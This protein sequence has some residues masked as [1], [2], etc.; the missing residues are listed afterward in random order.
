MSTAKVTAKVTAMSTVASAA[1]SAVVAV[2]PGWT[3]LRVASPGDAHKSTPSE[4]LRLTLLD[5]R[6]DALSVCEVGITLRTDCIVT[7]EP[8]AGASVLDLVA[9]ELSGHTELSGPGELSGPANLSAAARDTLPPHI[10]GQHNTGKHNTGQHNTGQHNADR[11]RIGL[12]IVSAGY[13]GI[14]QSLARIEEDIRSV[15]RAT[16]AFDGPKTKPQLV[17]VSD[18]P[19]VSALLGEVDQAVSHVA[20]SLGQLTRLAQIMQHEMARYDEPET[21]RA[22]ELIVEGQSLGRRLEFVV[23]R[24]LF[25]ARSSAQR[26]ST[27]DLNVIKVF[28]VLWAILIPGTTLINWY[29]Q[30]F[31]FMPELSWPHTATVQLIG[32]FVLAALPIY[33]IKRAGQLR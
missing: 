21:A 30:N 27:S 10:A 17:G 1:M 3:R 28:S 11:H 7:I 5:C 9:A 24:H 4:T 29:G 31:E 25:Y 8:A 18:L 14:R 23:D 26:V 6:D 15:H 12:A 16:S 20:L 2:A 13:A 19:A 22:Q 33:V 32:V